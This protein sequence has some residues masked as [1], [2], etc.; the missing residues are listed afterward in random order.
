MSQR[1]RDVCRK[2]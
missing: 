1:P 2:Y